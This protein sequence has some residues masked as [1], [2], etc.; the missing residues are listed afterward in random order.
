MEKRASMLKKRW[1]GEQ[2]GQLAVDA[3]IVLGTTQPHSADSSTLPKMPFSA[4]Q[5]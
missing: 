5:I 1:H 4:P 2:C 3:Y